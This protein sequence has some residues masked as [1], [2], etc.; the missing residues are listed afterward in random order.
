MS[1]PIDPRMRSAMRGAK[2]IAVYADVAGLDGG[3]MSIEEMMHVASSLITDVLHAVEFM[4]PTHQLPLS[5]DNIEDERM[6]R[7]GQ[8]RALEA[9]N[10]AIETYMQEAGHI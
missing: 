5:T 10:R 3:P 7:N 4:G 1:Q 2:P 8:L 9:M 6:L